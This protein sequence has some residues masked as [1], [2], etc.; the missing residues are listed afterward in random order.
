V[1]SWLSFLVTILLAPSFFL[2]LFVSR[3]SMNGLLAD[4]AGL[5]GL[6]EPG[7]HT[8]AV[9]GC[10]EECMKH[11]VGVGVGEVRVW[12]QVVRTSP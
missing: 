2:L 8:A 5:P 10:G 6:S 4:G 11:L 9:I 12:V 7:V 3:T 1:V